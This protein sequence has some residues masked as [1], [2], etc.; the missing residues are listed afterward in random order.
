MAIQAL[1]A[2]VTTVLVLG[3]SHSLGMVK[4]GGPSFFFLLGRELGRDYELRLSACPGSTVLDWTRES[5]VEARC[6][7]AGAYDSLA[8]PNLPADVAIVLLGTN[9]AAG[10]GEAAPL[11]TRRYANAM[12]ELVNALLGD[13]VRR[14]VLVPPPPSA[15]PFAGSERR[16][17][18][19]AYGRALRALADEEERI[20]TGP[21]LLELIEVGT[22]LE[23]GAVHLN[24]AGHRLV[25]E[26]LARELRALETTAP[27]ETDE[28]NR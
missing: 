19:A 25:A 4:G 26:R 7:M 20:S 17:R 16:T 12:R 28:P 22:H 8:R 13:G 24:A 14:V 27:P 5:P 2:A 10:F 11:S 1:L 23:P 15:G 18:L 9:D 3:D 6:S 21:D